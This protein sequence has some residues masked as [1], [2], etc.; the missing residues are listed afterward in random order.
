M[1]LEYD[2]ASRQAGDIAHQGRTFIRINLAELLNGEDGGWVKEG[3]RLRLPGHT[4][5]RSE[6]GRG[7]LRG[8][9][10][11]VRLL[12]FRRRGGRDRPG[13]GGP[14]RGLCFRDLG[15]CARH[16][17]PGRP[18]CPAKPC[19]YPERSRPPA[20]KPT[21]SPPSRSKS[22]LF[23]GCLSCSKSAIGSPSP[24]DRN[25][26]G[27]GKIGEEA[28]FSVFLRLRNAE[29]L[30]PDQSGPEVGSPGLSRTVKVLPCPSCEHTEMVPAV[31]SDDLGT[32]WPARGRSLC[33]SPKRY[34]GAWPGRVR[35]RSTPGPAP[36]CP[37]PCPRP[38]T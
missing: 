34:R 29:P 10:T 35:R 2:E 21:Y 11:P 31:V 17:A 38:R 20:A 22:A 36:R 19:A 30:R 5:A 6:T 15:Q 26:A 7:G 28:C 14:A 23:R 8:R 1:S 32:D 27:Y 13:Q 9:G 16:P 37:P 24:T 33:G 4:P 3:G 12:L 25:H 18:R